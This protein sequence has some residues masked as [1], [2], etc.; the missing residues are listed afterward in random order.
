MGLL[1]TGTNCL[2]LVCVM[3][4]NRV[5]APPARINAFTGLLLTAVGRRLA[6]GVAARARSR[7]GGPRRRGGHRRVRSVGQRPYPGVV[8]ADD[9]YGVDAL[10]GVVLLEVG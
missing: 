7:R 8:G 5:P 6:G 1:A 3:G 9:Q 4:R 10:Q 2:A